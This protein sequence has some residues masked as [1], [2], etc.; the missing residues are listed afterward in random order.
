MLNDTY[1]FRLT[2]WTVSGSNDV[3]TFDANNNE[4]TV[5][6][7]PRIRAKGKC[8]MSVVGGEVLLE[9]HG[10]STR[11]VPNDA[12][13]LELESNIPYLGYNVERT[14]AG[15]AILI[16]SAI[17]DN[18]QVSV[19]P[20]LENTGAVEFTCL[21]LPPKITCKKFYLNADN[22]RVSAQE[23]TTKPLPVEVILKLEFFEDQH[24]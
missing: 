13:F 24:S 12:R 23:Y 18:T 20:V 1:I 5:Q 4:F 14:D 7:P 15:N 10:G 8:R 17:T 9:A 3:V 19:T 11:I 6:V 22:E 21:E 2:N 16:A